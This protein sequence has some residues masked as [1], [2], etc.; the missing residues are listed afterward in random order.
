M[1]HGKCHL[2]YVSAYECHLQEVNQKK[3]YKANMSVPVLII[4]PVT[5]K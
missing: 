4:L 3:E 1:V 5:I 2:L